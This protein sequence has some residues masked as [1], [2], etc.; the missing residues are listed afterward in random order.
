MT[1]TSKVTRIAYL[2]VRFVIHVS[3]I[4]FAMNAAFQGNW[5]EAAMFVS[6]AFMTA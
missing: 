4:F 1:A 3:S 2:T 6:F 5:T